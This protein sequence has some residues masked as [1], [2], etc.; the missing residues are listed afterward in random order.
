M[1]DKLL[2]NIGM[3]VVSLILAFVVWMAVVNISN[4]IIDDSQVVTVEVRNGKVLE[5]QNLT[6]KLVEKDAVTVSY[7]VRTRDRSS[8]KASD[9]HAYIDLNDYN[10]TTAVP[11]TVEINKNKES[12]VK[13]NTI[14]AKPMIF[15]VKTER[16][17]SKKFELQVKTEGTPKEGYALGPISLSPDSVTVE[18]PESQI[19]Q[20]NHMGIEIAVDGVSDDQVSSKEPLFYDANGN[21]LTLGD[22]V[23]VDT[24]KIDYTASVLKAKN[25]TLDFNVTGK[26]AIGYR[27]TGIKSDV[28]SV[29]VVGTK[30]I[31]ASLTTLSVSSDKLNVD[32]A[33]GDKVVHLDL[34]QYLPPNTSI[35]GDEYKDVEVKMKVEPLTTRVF[36]LNLDSLAKMGFKGG[37]EYKFDQKTSDV[38]MK[39]LKEDLDSLKEEDLNAVLDLTNIKPGSQPGAL[40]F[41]VPAGTEVVG[42]T[43]FNVTVDSKNTESET[44]TETETRESDTEVSTEAVGPSS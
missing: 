24:D 27:Y 17:Q 23:T 16:L 44:E 21:T 4:P 42:F 33:T 37:Y 3:K 8:I 1:K 38:T 40:T 35:T 28:K 34:N 6:Y 41:E 12:L 10:I 7:K 25:L 19:G 32:G 31:L 20:I 11:V 5:D 2:H 9:F 39:G 36:T 13:S 43:P 29:P 22:Q 26:V 30:S 14:T 15:H 18:G